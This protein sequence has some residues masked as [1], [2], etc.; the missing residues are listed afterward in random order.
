M[1]PV[2]K[3]NKRQD[4][5][6][7]MR[8]FGTVVGVS[9][10]I[11][12]NRLESRLDPLVPFPH[13]HSFYHLVWIEQGTG[14]HEIDFVR[15]PVG[16]RQFFLMKPG[17]VHHWSLSPDTRGVVIEFQGTSLDAW[18][19]RFPDRID[20]QEVSGDRR[21]S[22]VHTLER[23]VQENERNENYVDE[24][25]RSELAILI[26]GI[27]R[28]GLEGK[29]AIPEDA[30]DHVFVRLVESHFDIEHSV[31]FYA[32][33]MRLSPKA[34]TM[35]ISRLLGK[36]ART[37]IQERVLLEAKRLLAYSELSISEVAERVGFDDPNYFARFFRTKEKR[38]PASFR[39]FSRESE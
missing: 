31:S 36:S 17:Q 18:A 15:Y 27:A 29:I 26:I 25:L 6:H 5:R 1:N 24:A 11:R 30:S 20:F 3:A 16:P 21:N 32:K 35:R 37:V 4:T 33:Q 34:L 8:E 19:Q 14:W 13:R 10:Q 12:A 23:M 7:G 9:G 28:T 2:K 38:S 22:I 39:K